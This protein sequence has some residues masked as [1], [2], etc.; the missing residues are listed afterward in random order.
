M[1]SLTCIT[2]V[3][4]DGPVLMTAVDSLLGQ[5][6]GDVQLLFVDDGSDIETATLLADLA[7]PRLKVIRQSNDGLS[8]ARNT[9]LRHATGDYICFLDADDSRPDWSFA[10][11]ATQLERDAPDVLFCPGA[12]ITHQGTPMPFF[13]TP[14]FDRIA[15]LLPEGVLDMQDAR[16]EQVWPL[17]QLIEPQSANKVV[18]RALVDRFGLG[19][20][21][22]HCF[23]DILFHSQALAAAERISIAA[24][25]CFSYHQH[26]ARPQITADTGQRRLDIIAVARLTLESA[27]NTRWID[28]RLYRSAVLTSCLR[29][30]EWCEGSIGHAHK[31]A[32]HDTLRGMMQLIDPR[33]RDF[34]R[35]ELLGLGVPVMGLDYAARLAHG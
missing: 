12:L 27:A 31:I 19:F 25:P 23:E 7:D 16:A 9:A 22:G 15:A 4:N 29:L 3:Y 26:Y 28:R 20:P 24:S 2:T 5:S 11:I 21:N 13:D 10:A 30:A 17:A 6:F 35:A 18:R 32:F 33:Y 1:P 34:A 8:S 14:I